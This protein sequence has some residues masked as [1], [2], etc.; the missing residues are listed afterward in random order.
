MT[1]KDGGV[2]LTKKDITALKESTKPASAGTIAT[3]TI[4]AAAQKTLTAD[5]AR[6]RRDRMQQLD[7]ERK[8]VR[9][10]LSD[11]ES[12]AL[13]EREQILGRAKRAMDEE[14]DDVKHMNMMMEYAK[15]A[16]VR[17]TQIQEK[18]R[19][20]EEAAEEERRL[21]QQ[22]EAERIKAIQREEAEARARSAEQRAGARMIVKQMHEREAERIRQQELR[23]QEAHVMLQKI[24]EAESKEE[25]ER[26]AKVEAGRRL[27]EQVMTANNAAAR[28]K[29]RKKQ[30]EVEEDMRIAEYLKA[31][32][33]RE[34]EME[35]E[36]ERVRAEREKEIARLRA[37]Q[38]KAQ[39]RQAALDE[40]RAK[41]Y[42]E[43]RDRQWRQ[44]QLDEAARLDAMKREIN[45]ARERQRSEK[46]R[47]LIEQAVL[48]KEEHQRLVQLQQEQMY[49]EAQREEDSR[50]KKMT[51]RDEVLQQIKHNQHER[52]HARQRY[53]EDGK[54]VA[55]QVEA[56]RRRLEAIKAA[57]L[58]EMRRMGI[59]EKYTAELAR[60]K[61]ASRG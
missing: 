17:E 29:L 54:A 43:Q 38:E 26:V 2:L 50:G 27:L 39:D 60:K 8:G 35:L 12:A 25:D 28:V 30:E 7:K 21:V 32:D 37:M 61:I 36:Q 45:D 15:C 24:K 3:R 49:R 22:M 59:P 57:K 41:R 34:R 56:E 10:H 46:E 19:L 52:E 33:A 11:V 13:A 6:A 51:L 18:Q 20:M 14:M 5:K 47:R 58:E 23:E 44:K 16:A 53:L 9:A 55:E 1:L 40:L 4:D 31:K 42:Q 48:E